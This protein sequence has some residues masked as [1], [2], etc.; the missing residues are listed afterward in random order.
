MEIKIYDKKITDNNK[1]E[2]FNKKLKPLIE[3]YLRANYNTK[4]IEEKIKVAKEKF[5]LK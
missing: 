5:G 3:E 4:E 2:L 1:K